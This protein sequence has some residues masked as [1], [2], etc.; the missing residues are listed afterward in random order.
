VELDDLYRS[1]PG[2]PLDELGL[3]LISE[4]VVFRHARKLVANRILADVT[5]QDLA[6]ALGRAWLL[7]LQGNAISERIRT[8][9][10]DPAAKWPNLPRLK[11]YRELAGQQKVSRRES[12]GVASRYFVRSPRR[13]P[14]EY[15]DH[16]FIQV[17]R[18]IWDRHSTSPNRGGGWTASGDG[19]CKVGADGRVRA[20]QEGPFQ[21]LVDDW[22][23][24]IHPFIT[25][26]AG[27]PRGISEVPA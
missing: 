16:L 9:H 25:A 2:H 26:A 14:I 27:R 1:L 19:A 18:V 24:Q 7:Y 8:Q 17:M 3:H 23:M 12:M 22:L 11:L 6:N 21:R 4:D 13:R 15:G 20:S 5:I 10:K